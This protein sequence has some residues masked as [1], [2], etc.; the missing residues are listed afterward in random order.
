MSIDRRTMLKGGAIGA[1]SFILAGRQVLLSPDQA[2]ARGADFQILTAEEAAAL[3]VL[4]DGLL[5]GAAE[6]GLSHYIDAQLAAPAADSF[7]MIRYLDVPPPWD[8][9]YK[10]IAHAAAGAAQAR[11]GKALSELDDD[12]L[13][14]LIAAMAAGAVEGWD[15][16]PAGLAYFALRSDAVDVTYGTVAGFERLGI[17]YLAHIEPESSW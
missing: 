3:D 11:S 15:G 10:G 1:L 2:R 12:E 5:P 14:G 16:P 13:A 7:L 6:A 17:P 9:V 4:G 8:G